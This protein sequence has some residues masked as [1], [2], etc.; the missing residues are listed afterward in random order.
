MDLDHSLQAL[1]AFVKVKPDSE[2]IHRCHATALAE[3][4]LMAMF[5]IRCVERCSISFYLGKS[6]P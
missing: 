2:I 5:L 4:R 1:L 3:G 6:V